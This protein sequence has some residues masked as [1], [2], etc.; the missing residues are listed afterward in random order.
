MKN[1]YGFIPKKHQQPDR[2]RLIGSGWCAI[3]KHPETGIDYHLQL[4]PNILASSTEEAPY[5]QVL[6]Q[7]KDC[8]RAISE[9]LKT[10][11]AA[12]AIVEKLLSKPVKSD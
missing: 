7:D 2:Y 5:I 4:Y 8:R 12:V 11:K 9:P 10:I 6:R 3:Y 1:Q